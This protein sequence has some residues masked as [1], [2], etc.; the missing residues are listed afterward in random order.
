MLRVKFMSNLAFQ[1]ISKHP[2]QRTLKQCLDLFGGVGIHLESLSLQQHSWQKNPGILLSIKV[3]RKKNPKNQVK[4]DN[5]ALNN[6][7]RIPECLESILEL[8]GC[9]RK[10]LR[11]LVQVEIHLGQKSTPKRKRSLKQIKFEKHTYKYN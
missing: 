11:I 5:L 8:S 10:N 2:A 9:S 3:P 1:L 6:K 7:T 4:S